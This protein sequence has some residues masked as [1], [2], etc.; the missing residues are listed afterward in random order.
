MVDVDP[1][2]LDAETGPGVTLGSE[3]LLIGEGWLA[4]P[5][6]AWTRTVFG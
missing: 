1:V 3:V 2:D 5:D 4:A 6:A